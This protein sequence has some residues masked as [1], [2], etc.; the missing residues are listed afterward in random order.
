MREREAC[1]AC[2]QS[3]GLGTSLVGE[4]VGSNVR[5][6]CR[7]RGRPCLVQES[8]KKIADHTLVVW[9]EPTA[10]STPPTRCIA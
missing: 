2:S 4:S 3:E 9:S 5:S 1:Q 7:S 6:F 10:P 8:G